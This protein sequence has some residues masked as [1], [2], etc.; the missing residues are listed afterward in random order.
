MKIKNSIQTR[1]LSDEVEEE[2]IV[3][4]GYRPV[5]DA[6]EEGETV[7]RF[8]SRLFGDGGT[9]FGRLCRRVNRKHFALLATRTDLDPMQDLC[10]VRLDRLHLVVNFNIIIRNLVDIYLN[11][12]WRESTS[13]GFAV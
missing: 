6:H 12:V 13:A 1:K 2:L 5:L 3:F 10:C 7:G 11:R 9:E 8:D 4:D